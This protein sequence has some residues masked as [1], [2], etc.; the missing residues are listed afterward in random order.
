MFLSSQLREN[1]SAERLCDSQDGRSLGMTGW[2]GGRQ[3]QGWGAWVGRAPGE[4]LVQDLRGRQ[5]GPQDPVG[6]GT[7]SAPVSGWRVGG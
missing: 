2:Q 4:H 1:S 3:G 5:A 6:S 7:S